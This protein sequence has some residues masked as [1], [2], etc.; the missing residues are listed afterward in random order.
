MS[1]IEALIES[2]EIDDARCNIDTRVANWLRRQG[3]DYRCD[4]PGAVWLWCKEFNGRIVAV[5]PD[6]ARYMERRVLDLSLTE[7]EE[8]ELHQRIYE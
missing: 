8:E 4:F 5:G 3:W 7:A 6:Q 2:D 1:K